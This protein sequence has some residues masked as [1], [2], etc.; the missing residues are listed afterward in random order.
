MKLY[1][2]TATGYLP[3][4]AANGLRKGEVRVSRAER[5]NAVSVPSDDHAGKGATTASRTAARSAPRK[6]ASGGC[7]RMCRR[8]IPTSGPSGL[9]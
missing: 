1:H 3:S 7:R 5:L 9:P 4:I 2:Y 8:P 6:S